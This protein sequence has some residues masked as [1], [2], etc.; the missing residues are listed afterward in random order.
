MADIQKQ[1]NEFHDSIK[2][3]DENKL[4]Q[5]KKDKLKDDLEEN[6]KEEDP[7][8]KEYLLQGS[9]AIY[10]GIIP[11]DGDY[12]IDVG[13]VL[14]CN[15]ND[16]EPVDLKEIVKTALQNNFRIP[17]IRRPCVTTQYIKNGKNEY[18]VDMP[19]YVEENGSYYIAMG[20]SGSSEDKKFWELSDPKY[21]VDWINGISDD[22]DER[23]QF[24]RIVKYLK[25]WNSHKMN[26]GN[27][28]PSIAI[29]IFSRYYFVKYIDFY[30]NKP[31]DLKALRSIVQSILNNFHFTGY[32]EKRSPIYRISV[33]LPCQP[34]SDTF[35]KVTDKKMK[36]FKEKLEKFKNDL[37]E[38]VDEERPEVACELISKHLKNFP[39]PPKEST[40]QKTVKSFTNVGSSS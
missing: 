14:D 6:L 23:A 2:L 40:A 22:S 8:V 3:T 7:S 25:Y 28:L 20:K 27:P 34:Y 10:T 12:D 26:D 30:S 1:F 5:E 11:K 24:R 16:Y 31:N 9:Y 36:T 19:V 29:T 37:D 33:N 35:A 18:H 39:I 13:V 38:A 17:K 15:K 21:L 32:D 4:L